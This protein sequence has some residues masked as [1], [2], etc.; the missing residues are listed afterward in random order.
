MPFF[1]VWARYAGS[2]GVGR[3]YGTG[4]RFPERRL[5]EYDGVRTKI[6]YPPVALFELGLASRVAQAAA[7]GAAGDRALTYAIK[8]IVVLAEAALALLVFAALSID[9]TS[10]ARAALRLWLDPGAILIGSVLGYLEPLYLLPVMASLLAAAH[11]RGAPAGAFL[12]IACLTKPIAVFFVPAVAV[13]VW[14]AGR[15]VIVEALV[16]AALAAA[17]VVTP[18]VLHGG[19]PNMLWGVGSLLRDPF[20]TG[21][22]LNLWWLAGALFAPPIDVSRAAGAVATVAAIAWAWTRMRRA[23]DAGWL[24]AGAAFAVHAYAVLAVSVHENHLFAAVPPLVLAAAARPRFR[25]VLAAVSSVSG[26]NLLMTSGA[27]AMIAPRALAVA[28]AVVA[29]ANCAAL[30]WHATVL[31]AE[32]LR[33]S[34]ADRTGGWDGSR[35]GCSAAAASPRPARTSP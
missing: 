25:G 16:A 2:E 27:S 1:R 8:A 22:A 23:T 35:A 15:R 18:V 24:S 28:G 20:L 32:S 33:P 14:H 3:L 13:G 26:L 11:G 12:S 19:F 10:G 4:G 29:V 5:L 34:V 31:H 30:V 17:L 7:G 21:N 9:P 6:D